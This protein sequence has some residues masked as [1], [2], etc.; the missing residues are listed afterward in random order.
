VRD[1]GRKTLCHCGIS[2]QAGEDFD[3]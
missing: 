2:L 1:H 3:R